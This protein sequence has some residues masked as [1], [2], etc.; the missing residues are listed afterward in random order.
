MRV[1]LPKPRRTFLE[2]DELA[3]LL[4]AAEDQ[5]RPPVIAVSTDGKHS[6]RDALPCSPQAECARAASR[7]SSGSPSPR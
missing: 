5:E 7:P 1:R 2:M 6:T 3:E 4:R